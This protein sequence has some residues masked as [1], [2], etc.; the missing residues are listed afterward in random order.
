MYKRIKGHKTTLQLYTERLVA[1]GLIPEGEIEDM[2]AAFQAKLN[3]EFET[4]KVYKPNKADWLDGRWAGMKAIRADE[5]DPRRGAT[6]VP[7]AVASSP[8][9][10][11]FLYGCL[12]AMSSNPHRCV[13]K[14]AAALYP[15][16]GMGAGLPLRPTG[17][18]VIR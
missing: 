18:D 8:I 2:K 14:S 7:E 9:F 17:P 3:E 10:M 12:P 5:D 4:G 6:G 16:C 1:D 13:K 11:A 15:A